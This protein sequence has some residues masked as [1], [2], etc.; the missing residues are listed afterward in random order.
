[1][2]WSGRTVMIALGAVLG[3]SAVS[4]RQRTNRSVRVGF[5]TSIATTLTR[6]SVDGKPHDGR[7]ALLRGSHEVETFSL[8][9][10]L[11]WCVRKELK[12]IKSNKKLRPIQE[13]E[14]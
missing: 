5:G 10:R 12:R 9:F 1:M 13:M 6:A 14:Q 8:N 4:D 2:C 11:Y 3:K 7:L